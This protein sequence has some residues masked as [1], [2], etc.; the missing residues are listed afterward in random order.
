[1]FSISG[2]ISGAMISA[3]IIFRV[4]GGVQANGSDDIRNMTL[5]AFYYAI[6]HHTI[7]H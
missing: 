2:D 5:N 6:K 3:K 7:K 1:M 4:H